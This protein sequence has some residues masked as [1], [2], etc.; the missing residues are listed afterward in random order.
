MYKLGRIDKDE[1]D[2]ECGEIDEQR[3]HL[4]AGPPAP[5]FQQQ[6]QTL[7]TLVEEW[8][9]MTNDERKRML[10]AIFHSITASAEGVQR[11][12]PC[13]QWR[14]YVIAAIPRP[15]GRAVC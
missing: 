5:L 2:V 11:L 7:T 10:A 4:T 15:V 12:E 14:P 9:G 6:Q 8:A 13:E 1:Y 3:A